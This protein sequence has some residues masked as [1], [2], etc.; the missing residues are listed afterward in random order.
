MPKK[1]QTVGAPFFAKGELD[2]ESN[3]KNSS[4]SQQGIIFTSYSLSEEAV[5]SSHGN[6]FV[7]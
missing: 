1:G 7:Y 3:F 5:S 6:F 2:R 4:L